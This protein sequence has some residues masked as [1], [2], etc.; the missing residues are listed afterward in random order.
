M[1]TSL[2]WGSGTGIGAASVTAVKAQPTANQTVTVTDG[3]VTTTSNTFAVNPAAVDALYFS[4]TGSFYDPSFNGQPLDTKVGAPIF[5]VCA[6]PAASASNPCGLAPSPSSGVR[7]LVL[8]QFGN[9]V[10]DGTVVTLGANPASTGKG[11]ATTLNGVADFGNQPVISALGSFRLKAASGGKDVLSATRM[12]VT[13]LAACDE[14]DCR[15]VANNNGGK[16]TQFAYGRI[17]TGNDF[18]DPGRTNVLLTTQFTT[19]VNTGPTAGRDFQCGS[20]VIGDW[21]TLEVQGGGIV[22]T[23]PDTDM[24]LILPKDTLKEFKITSRGTSSFKVCL[25]ALWIGAGSPTAWT[26]D[27]GKKGPGV[28]SVLKADGRYWGSPADCGSSY[29]SPTDPCIALR[30][31][32]TV[33]IQNYFGMTAAE[34]G[35]IMRDADLAIVIHKAFPWDGKGGIY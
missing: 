32:Q 20:S 8:D 14:Q 18:Y 12:I 35:A 21:T 19:V 33:D 22:T 24:L 23:A 2:T 34:V 30:T 6:P 16:K 4:T 3:T 10:S 9:R 7:V 27:G 11:S 29:L 5:S 25:G 1:P 13:D 17:R 28:A 31:K 15:N 26:A